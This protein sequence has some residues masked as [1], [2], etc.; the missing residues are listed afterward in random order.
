MVALVLWLWLRARARPRP[1]R[2][3]TGRRW[4][5]PAASRAWSASRTC[6]SWPC[7]PPTC[8]VEARCAGR[9]RRR[10]A[11][12]AWRSSAAAAL[13]FAPQ[14]LAYRALNGSFGPSHLVDAQDELLQPALPS[15]CSSIPATACS[16]GARCCSWPR[17]AWSSRRRAAA[18]TPVALLAAGA[19]PAGVDQRRASRAGPRRGPSARAA[20]SS[21]TPSSPGAW[22]RSWRP[23]CRALGARRVAAAAGLFV[24]W[25]VSLMVQF[26]LRLMDRQR[27]EWPRVAVNQVTEV[28]RG[29][30]PRGLALPDRPRAAGAGDAVISP[31]LLERRGLPR[32]PRGAGLRGVPRARR[33]GHDGL[34]GGLRRR[35]ALR[36]RR[37][38][39]GAPVAGGGALRCPCC[40][41]LY[42]V[43]ERSAGTW[44]SSRAAPS[45][46]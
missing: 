15:R 2:P 21:S 30:G 27:L 34:R 28:P 13:A 44:T 26:G 6:S 12:P 3:G 40:R 39:Q 37:A 38:G 29:A 14:L 32:V 23:R 36:L 18:G 20:S 46:R 19:A 4:A 7:P 42:P 11:W 45:A 17:R 43:R 22:P 24:W 8:A 35:A 5:R 41:A 9:E 33:G 10:R 25:N 1:R 16:P 31:G